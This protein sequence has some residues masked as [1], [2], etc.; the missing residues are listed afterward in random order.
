MSIAADAA[1]AYAGALNAAE[2]NRQKNYSAQQGSGRRADGRSRLREAYIKNMQNALGL[3][4]NMKASGISGGLS[5]STR[6]L[7]TTTI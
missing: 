1:S 5:E 7:M 6:R 2:Q 4:Q 3:D